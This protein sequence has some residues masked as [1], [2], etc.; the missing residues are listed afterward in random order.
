MSRPPEPAARL[1]NILLLMS[2]SIACAKATGLIS[3]WVKNGHQV[4]VACTPA[5]AHFVGAATLEGFSGHPVH[6]DTFAAGQVMDHVHLV[7]WADII[8]AAPATANLINKLAAGIADDAV[9]SIWLA[10]WGRDKPM[11]L[12][13]AMNTSMWNYPATRDS[14]ARL[15]SWGVQVLPTAQGNLACGE[16]GAGRMLEPEEILQHLETLYDATPGAGGSRILITAGGT[17]EPIDT[18]RYIGNLSTGRTAAALADEM[19]AMGHQVTWLGAASAIRPG[20]PYSIETFISY[21][22]LAQALQRLLSAQSFDA[23]IHAAAVSDFSVAG[24][25][26]ANGARAEPCGK[27]PS[28]AP[29]SLRLKPNAKLLVHLRDWSGSDRARIIGFKLTDHASGQQRRAAVQSQFD[30]AAVDAVVHNDLEDIDA[31]RH[32]FTFYAADG[33]STAC[34]DSHALAARIHAMLQPAAPA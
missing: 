24:I 34:P 19:I 6:T 26:Q 20:R 29:V 7:Q 14:I 12:V 32:P 5:V 17:R 22:D 3:T 23:V 25:E 11:I 31:S 8:I 28:C 16:L 15:Q 1:P 30:S 27:L 13:P 10:A 4:Q 18:V 9:T 2:G 21:A 33:T